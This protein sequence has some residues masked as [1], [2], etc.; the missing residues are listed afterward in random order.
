[1]PEYRQVVPDPIFV[2]PLL[3]GS[4]LTLRFR[5][6]QE[7][8]DSLERSGFQVVDVRQAPDRPDREDV[9]IAEKPR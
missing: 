9:F 6:R 7:I 1:M 8:E 2:D 5:E 3:I 4:D